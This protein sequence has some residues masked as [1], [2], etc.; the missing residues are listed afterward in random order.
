M[1]WESQEYVKLADN[2]WDTVMR[3]SKTKL[4]LS[5][6][7]TRLMPFTIQL[8]ESCTIDKHD[9]CNKL[10]YCHLL[11][12]K[13]FL[14]L[15]SKIL[16]NAYTITVLWTPR[17]LPISITIMLETYCKNRRFCILQ[18]QQA[19]WTFLNSPTIFC[20]RFQPKF[21]RVTSAQY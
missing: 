21:I 19:I 3:D 10:N 16:D 14:I 2:F 13:T 1:E 6:N 7:S 17:F 11:T 15:I 8:S 9:S 5:L 12:E 20:Y 18:R 4:V